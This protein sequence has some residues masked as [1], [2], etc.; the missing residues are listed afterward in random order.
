MYDRPRYP[1][2]YEISHQSKIHNDY[3]DSRET[4]A[5]Q[6]ESDT[7]NLIQSFNKLSPNEQEIDCNI[8]DDFNSYN[9]IFASSISTN[10]PLPVFSKSSHP[11]SVPST[12]K[13]SSKPIGTNKFYGNILLDTQTLPVWTH[14][15]SVWFSKDVGYEG[16]ATCQNSKSS[17]T[18]GPDPNASNSQYFY[19]QVGVKQI[20]LGSL[21]FNSSTTIGL[22]NIK[23]LSTDIVIQSSCYGRLVCPTVQ[24]QGFITG[25]YYNL[26]PK[27]TSVVGFKEINLE[28][29][30]RQGIKKYK[31]LLQ[32]NDTWLLYITIPRE[33]T[34]NLDLKNGN[35]IVAGNPV[36]GV[37][38]QLSANDDAAFDK[39]AGS[40]PT[41]ATLNGFTSGSSGVYSINYS[42][43][44]SSNNGT[45]VLYA[46]PH[47]IDTFTRDMDSLKTNIKLETTTK[48]T[49]IAYLTN[50]LKFK[51]S[52]P[53]D[54]S[55]D[56]YSSIAGASIRYSKSAIDSIRNASLVE[57]NHDILNLSNVDSMYTSGKIL[58]KY[59][60][61]LYVTHYV[62]KDHD[63][64]TTLLEK[65]K[66]AIERFSNNK[67]QV[68]L[69]YDQTWKGIVSTADFSGDFGNSYYNDHHF[70]YGYHVM[71]S[72]ITAKVDA[73][74][75]GSFLNTIKDWVNDLVRDIATPSDDDEYFPAFRSFDW[76][77][78]HSWAKGLFSSG[79]GKDEE[80]SSED[81]NSWFA[82]KIWGEVIGDTALTQRSLLQLGIMKNSVNHYFLYSNNNTTEPS[83]IIGNKVSGI[84]FE[85]KIDHTTYFGNSIQYIQMIHAIPIS[86]ISSYIR[87]P[88][89]VQEEW[90]QKLES[91]VDNVTDGWKGIIYLNLALYDPKSSFEFFNSP[92]FSDNYLDNG[93][94]KTWSLAYSGA[95]GSS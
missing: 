62:L 79:D 8:D 32:N 9:N 33:E 78:G 93:Q 66:I 53:A 23:H 39:V 22:E 90:K 13:N 43:S 42:V 89:F 55:L 28:T 14:P 61:V 71:A 92:S 80:S 58:A 57:V 48:G 11:I 64:T 15:Y 85:N 76:Y 88:S 86:S 60:W 82:T 16:L 24:G 12:V 18:F 74:L 45:T 17:R 34:L 70:H 19:S 7:S 84:L 6:Y 83:K 3:F 40:Y 10:H 63:L 21:D 51:L 94:S 2:P 54:I 30:P 69:S 31:I 29:S 59:S 25:I 26:T 91:V 68:P 72:A 73:E 44:G 87:N 65:L 20:I 81:Y 37:V 52:V 36:N 56:P 77:N 35:T 95:F 47:H 50:K 27:L 41:S 5:S 49:A 67:Q 1:T 75:G 4:S 38:F 46:L